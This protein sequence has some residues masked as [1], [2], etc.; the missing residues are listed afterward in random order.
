MPFQN[1]FD[2]VYFSQSAAAGQVEG[3]IWTTII[4]LSNLEFLPL[5]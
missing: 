4:I 5:V 3:A 1:I 2:P